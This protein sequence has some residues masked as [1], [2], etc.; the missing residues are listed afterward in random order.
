MP[1]GKRRHEK[2]LRHKGTKQSFS[3]FVS[4]WWNKV[5]ASSNSNARA[6]SDELQVDGVRYQ[7]HFSK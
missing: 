3:A 5:V 1:A 7:L 6:C 2:P 4:L